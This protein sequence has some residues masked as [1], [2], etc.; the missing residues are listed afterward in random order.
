MAPQV[1]GETTEKI[2]AIRD[3]LKTVHSRQKS[4]ADLH[5]GEIEFSIGD[6]VFLKVSSMLGVTKFGIKGKLAPRYIGP[7]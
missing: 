7:F 6:S 5:R 2:Q 3:W 1:I 4:Y